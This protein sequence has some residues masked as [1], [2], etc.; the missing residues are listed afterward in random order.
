V[1]AQRHH[2]AG[3][4]S[5]GI[6]FGLQSQDEGR[7]AKRIIRIGGGGAGWRGYGRQSYSRRAGGWGISKIKNS[8]LG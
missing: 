4:T 2:E 5:Q 3:N 1:G 7:G 6:F 8:S